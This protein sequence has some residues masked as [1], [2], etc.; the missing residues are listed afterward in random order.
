MSTVPGSAWFVP[1][2]E[3]PR[4]DARLRVLAL[5]QAGAGVAA[6]A[7]CAELLGPDI[8]M[9]G[10]NLPGRQARFAEPVRT[11]L[12]AL[13]DDIAE[14][15]DPDLL[16]PLPYLLFGYCSG[17]LLAYVLADALRA[18]NLPAP[19]GLVVA[20]YPSPGLVRPATTL[21]TLPTDE[22]WAEIAS[23]GGFPVLLAEQ[24][25]FREIFEPALRG[26]YELLAGYQPVDRAPFDFPVTVACGRRD[27]VHDPAA[28]LAWR[29]HT[30]G[31]FALELID[32]DHWLLAGTEAS[33]AELLT[34]AAHRVA[35]PAGVR[36]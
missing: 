7:E 20:S 22:F 34:A 11:E 26:D 31:R 13:I 12:G 10:L 21:H 18:R 15:I 3:R 8:A 16:A 30:T 27:P 4:P 1:L 35:T 6:F 2:T 19:A 9:Y 25:D 36:G 28:L 32:G 5:P 17:A 29:R 33:L 14:G 23:Y 24:P